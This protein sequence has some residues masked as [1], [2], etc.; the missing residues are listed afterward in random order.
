MFVRSQAAE[1]PL[2]QLLVVSTLAALSLALLSQVRIVLPFTPVP[3]TMQT[4]GVLLLAA[5][6]GPRVGALAVAEFVLLGLCGMPC[7]AGLSG[8][9]GLLIGATGGYLLAFPIA[10]FIAGL[11]YERLMTGGYARR[12][13]GALVAGMAGAGVIL[14]GG[15]AWLTVLFHGDLTKAFL[16]GFLPF[17]LIDAL[18]AVVVATVA[19]GRK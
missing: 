12:L 5:F 13:A 8:G 4:L 14:I 18:K 9:T 19:A 6:L 10:A 1:R 7:F 2:S 16:V 3:I 11:L 15:T 17:T